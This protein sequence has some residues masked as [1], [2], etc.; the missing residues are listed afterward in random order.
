MP[1]YRCCVGG[2]YNDS[3]YVDK[4][5]KRG[6]VDGELRW[7][8]FPKQPEKR[9]QWTRNVSKG[10]CGFVASDHKTVCSN[11]FQYGKPT[12]AAPNPTLFL[13]ES[14]KKKS[15]PRKRKLPTRRP[16]VSSTKEPKNKEAGSQCTIVDPQAYSSLTFAHLTRECD[17]N[18]FTGLSVD[19]FRLIFDHVKDKALVM[20]YWK[21]PRITGDTS[22]PKMNRQIQHFSGS[23]KLNIQYMG[24][25]LT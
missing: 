8:H 24:Q 1:V 16:V 15:S 13:V 12:F 6:H 2:C 10:L 20:H 18:N 19:R 22:K 23:I 21:G 14:D 9:E 17:S 5:V 3:R 4:I 11:H 25:V 7:H